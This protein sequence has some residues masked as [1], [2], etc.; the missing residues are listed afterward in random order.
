MAGKISDLPTLQKVGGSK[1]PRVKAAPKGDRVAA[2]LGHAMAPAAGKLSDNAPLAKSQRPRGTARLAAVAAKPNAAHSIQKTKT[3]TANLANIK[4][5]PKV[6]TGGLN[7]NV[8]HDLGKAAKYVKKIN[9]N[10]SKDVLDL[11]AG[12]A[13]SAY[14]LGA[15]A[16]EAVLNGDT[17]R[18]KK[19]AKG[20]VQN[21]PIALTAQGKFK[22]A[23]KA[24]EAHPGD[25]MAELAGGKAS[26]GSKVTRVQEALGKDVTARVAAHDPVTN[27]AVKRTYSRDPI[28][29]AVQKA[30]EAK[31]VNTAEALRAEADAAARSGAT[32]DS[33]ERKRA[34]ANKIDPRI[35]NERQA[36]VA[37]ARSHDVSKI[38]AE[39]HSGALDRAV[40]DAMG[41]KPNAALSLHAQRIAEPTAASLMSYRK[42][43]QLHANSGKLDA[44]ELA[45]NR[46]ARRDIDAA[47]EA[48]ID[49][50]KVRAASTKVEAVLRPVQQ[51]LVDE[52]ILPGARARKSPLVGY[53]VQHMEGVRPGKEGPVM[54][55]PG[56]SRPVKVEAADIEAHMRA[57]GIDPGV[58]ISQRAPR[59]AGGPGGQSR[60][61][62][63]TGAA[64][65]GQAVHVGTADFSPENIR[66]TAL[67]Q[68]SILDHADAYKS[69]LRQFGAD[70]NMTRTAAVKY[71]SDMSARH[72][73]EYVAVPK[74]PFAGDKNV[75]RMA[76]G[77]IDPASTEGLTAFH[78]AVDH[79]LS[80][81]SAVPGDYTVLP[82]SV[83]EEL[84]AQ[85]MTSLPK[86]PVR[87]TFKAIS[88]HFSRNVLSTSPS[89]ITGNAVEG[90]IRSWFAGTRPGDAKLF[91]AVVAKMRE[92]DPRMADELEA[93]GAGAGHHGSAGRLE[94]GQ[95]LAQYDHTVI[96]PLAHKLEA[97]WQRPGPK[98]VA[99]A[100]NAY[101]NFMFKTVSGRMESNLQ[102]SM[103]GALIRK[104]GIVPHNL[105]KL[106]EEAVSQAAKG[107]INTP[108][109]AALGE[110]LGQMFGRYSGR[111]ADAKWAITTY[112]PFAN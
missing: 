32:T 74:M 103:S 12:A 71:A 37:A 24:I 20:F 15:A 41:D 10:F 38:V 84:R 67:A 18:A 42:D 96:A 31:S 59:I 62:R 100:W 51:R 104:A 39:R 64:R 93:R 101:T 16:K 52:G 107:L 82:K 83:A 61:S 75:A 92:T 5:P 69:K 95:F 57:R 97:M 80:G 28:N 56:H 63:I 29:R 44:H 36:R 89:W 46:K 19:L 73:Q 49:P 34:Q 105:P 76:S 50:S 81:E 13:Q 47:I 43:L 106:S 54:D 86:G 26:L 90:Q 79:A 30:R 72:G 11:P 65:T 3:G 21:D 91:R 25:F 2:A 66:R 87:N 70:R 112:T 102:A 55:L 35:T 40:K 8:L 77:S 17:S 23:G 27:F 108:E 22:Q 6:Q 53:A 85:S 110:A 48:G 58:Y 78:G 99:S 7:G 1:K 94:H 98:A 111:T 109:Q 4:S 14:E 45:A 60:A 9:T 33:I 68:Q 88:T